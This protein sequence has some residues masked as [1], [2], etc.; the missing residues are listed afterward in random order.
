MDDVSNQNS[1]DLSNRNDLHSKLIPT[2]PI[3]F[4]EYDSIDEINE[5]MGFDVL[6][7]TIVEKTGDGYHVYAIADE[8]IKKQIFI[9][10]I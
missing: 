9:S 5:I 2:L 3:D 10:A 6:K 1:T 8:N 4:D 7:E